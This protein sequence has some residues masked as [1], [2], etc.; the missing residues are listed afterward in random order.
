MESATAGSH[1]LTYKNHPGKGPVAALHP[2]F[3]TIRK[4]PRK[5]YLQVPAIATLESKLAEKLLRSTR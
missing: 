1:G 5:L 2:T 4:F 3:S